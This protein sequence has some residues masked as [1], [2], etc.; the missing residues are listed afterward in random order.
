M[1]ALRAGE[2]RLVRLVAIYQNGVGPVLRPLVGSDAGK[3]R[4]ARARPMMG[5][6]ALPARQDC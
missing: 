2:H 6:C 1:T 5:A 4:R 3:A